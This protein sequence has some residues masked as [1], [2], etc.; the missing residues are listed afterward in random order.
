MLNNFKIVNVLVALLIVFCLLQ[1]GTVAV[2]FPILSSDRENFSDQQDI[3]N[4]RTELTGAWAY[5]LRTRLQSNRAILSYLLEDG[6]TAEG[7]K[8]FNEQLAAAKER[9]NDAKMYWAAYE[10]MPHHDEKTFQELKQS[11]SILHNSLTDLIGFV[12]A[13]NTD[14]AY[15]LEVQKSQNDF[16]R[17]YNAVIEGMNTFNQKAIND[18]QSSYNMAVWA[19]IC[20]LVILLLVM[21]GVWLGVRVTLLTP[22]NKLVNSI[23]H[24]SRGDLIHN[25]DV[26]GSNEMGQLAK[27]LRSMQAG[28]VNTVGEIRISADTILAGASEISVNNNNL[29]SRT[30]QQAAALEETA[31]S[32]EE[33]TATVKQNAENASEASQL[34]LNTSKTAQRGGKVV[35]DVVH[36]MSEIADSSRKIAHITNV[37]DNIAFQTNIL[38]LN[39]AVEAARAGEQGRGFAVVATEVRTLAQRSAEAAKDIKMLIEDSEE[40][41]SMGSGLVTHAGETMSEIVDA[42]TH[43]TN[44]MSE[45]ASASDEQS[46]GIVQV[47][48]AVTEMDQVTQQNASL[49]EES[50]SAATLLEAQACH[51]TEVVAMFRIKPDSD[52]AVN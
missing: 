31:A 40:K 34:A 7:R 50:A 24:I 49:V 8:E 33:L 17:A 35:N 10:A 19:V 48:V 46:R 52:T 38:A 27:S 9:F 3:S 15:Q 47:G 26:H 29:S 21:I 18:S 28:L 14:A 37:I 1:M 42:V 2:F 23:H 45:I 4:Q 20:I 36:T 39:A 32:M 22:L 6:S 13:G 41:V 43:V 44:I 12:D 30:E 51:L 5:L 11:Y 16:E 25:I